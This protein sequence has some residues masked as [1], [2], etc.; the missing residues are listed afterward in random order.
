MRVNISKSKFFAEQIEYLGYWITRQVIQPIHIKGKMFSILK[1]ME[2]KI[3]KAQWLHQLIGIVNFYRNMWFC[4]S[5][6]LA[7]IHWLAPH[8]SRSR[9]N[10]THP[11][12]RR[13]I[14][15]RNSLEFSYL[16]FIKTSVSFCHSTLY[17]CIRSSMVGGNHHV[18]KKAYRLLFAKAQNSKVSCNH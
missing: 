1:I 16:S 2:P 15:S 8:Q 13:L 4:R 3:R 18:E 6:I 5:D 9:L 10:G 12:N 17:G 14:Q 11:I 7:R